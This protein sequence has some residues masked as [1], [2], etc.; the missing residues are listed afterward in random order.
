MRPLVGQKHLFLPHLIHTGQQVVVQQPLDFHMQQQCFTLCSLFFTQRCKKIDFSQVMS[1]QSLRTK[2][3]NK[4]T[5]SA[6]EVCQKGPHGVKNSAQQ[7]HLSLFPA[8]LINSKP[9]MPLTM[10]AWE[11]IQ[12]SLIG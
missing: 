11:I 6:N 9:L 12:F 10:T 5:K 4:G 2:S 3:S 8:F 7:S 1:S